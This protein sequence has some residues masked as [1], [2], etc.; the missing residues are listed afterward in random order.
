MSSKLRAA[1]VGATGYTGAELVRLLHGHP[2]ISLAGLYAHTTAGQPV[3][4]V[5]P[6]LAGRAELVRAFEGDVDADLV[7]CG[8]PHGASAPIVDALREQGRVVFDLSADF[9][10][11]D[12]GVYR[13]WYGEHG[14]PSRFGRAVY[15]LPEL[16]REALRTADLVAVPGCYP[17]A[18]ILALAPLVANGLIETERPIIVDAKSGVSGAGRKVRE[19]THF[20]ETSEGIRAYAT[21]GRHR[22]T[23]EIEQ[24]LSRLAGDR[25]SVVFSPHLVPM[26]RG[27]LAT[28]YVQPKGD[29]ARFSTAA[30]AFYEGSPSVRVLE[31]GSHPDT[32]WVRGSNAAMVSYTLDRRTG[33]VV[34]QCA[35][36]NLVKG[37]SGQAIQCANVRFG[38]PEGA[39]VDHPATWP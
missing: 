5:L 29:P 8:L 24:E 7:F 31:D 20:S 3:G 22:H 11:T 23:P 16:H 12:L 2:S 1:V 35:I 13:E 21:A 14:A 9:R 34:A 30:R 28:T 26:I 15:G 37:A 39:G 36:D 19:S 25:I 18:S 32:L 17:T 4:E 10:L 38:L 6:S 33:W 27:I